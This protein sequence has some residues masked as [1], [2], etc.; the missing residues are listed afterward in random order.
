MDLVVEEVEAEGRLRL[1]LAIQLPLQA[2][3]LVGRFQ[4][5]RQSPPPRQ[6]RK[7]ARSQGPSLPRSYPASAVLRPCPTPAGPSFCNDVEAATLAATGLPRYPGHLSGVPCP[8]PRRTRRVRASVASP[9]VRPSPLFRRVGVRIFTFEACSGFT[10]V[11][12]RRIAQPPKAAF[13]T[14][15]RP[16]QL[17]DRAARQ[18]PEQPT[19]LWVEPSSTGDPR[20]RGARRVEDGRGSLG[21]MANAPFPIPAHRTGRADFR[22]PALRPASSPGYRRWPKMHASKVDDA[23]VPEDILTAEPSCSPSLHL[24]PLDEEVAHAVDMVVDGPIGRQAGSVAELTPTIPAAS[25]SPDRPRRTTLP[26]CRARAP[27]RPCP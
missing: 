24:V 7:R 13:V 26:C 1:R 14:R 15:L 11:T 4:A 22:H 6:R 21:P 5:H 16:G 20:P 8:L 3:D 25:G 2:P 17:P 19:T 10:R 27:R 23:E 9:S 18:L 12:A